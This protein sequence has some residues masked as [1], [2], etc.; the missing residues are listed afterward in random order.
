MTTYRAKE[1]AIVDQTGIAVVLAS[2]CTKKFVKALA[3]EAA[4]EANRLAE[5]SDEFTLRKVASVQ[6]LAQP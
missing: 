2:N 4:M 3:Q 6:S 5:S 1:N